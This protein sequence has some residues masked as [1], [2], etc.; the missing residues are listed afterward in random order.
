M[1]TALLLLAAASAGAAGCASNDISLSIIQ[2]EA[3]TRTTNCIAMSIPIIGVVGRTR[4]ILDVAKT[5]M[6]GYIGIPIVRNNLT[7]NL[8]GV[9]Y[10]AIQLLGAN[11]K[12]STAD[13]KPLALSTGQ[14]EFF[15][16]SA[17]G[18]LDPAGTAAMPVE[19]VS[20]S[21]ARSLAGMIPA[22]GVYTVVGELRPVGMHQNDQV[23]G[24][25]L[26]YPV[27][28]CNGCLTMTSTCPLPKGSMPPDPCPGFSQQDDPETCCTDPTTGE[29][30]CGSAAPVA[31][32]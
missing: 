8:N 2:M 21:L 13:G 29:L 7:S 26:D 19:I 20:A 5:T 12:L 16:A 15:Y 27:D 28:L 1:K 6:T 22:S 32:M 30:K 23:I 10:N 31:T 18:R 25:P 14:S 11:I 17:G 9:E 4:G 3:I 24:G